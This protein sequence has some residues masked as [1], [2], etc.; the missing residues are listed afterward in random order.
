MVV[1]VKLVFANFVGEFGSNAIFGHLFTDT[2]VQLAHLRALAHFV[3][4]F[5][6]IACGLH[7][8]APRGCP[9]L[10]RPRFVACLALGSG[11]LFFSFPV[12]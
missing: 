7:G 11:F 8:A 6:E 3:A 12:S 4:F 2:R 9:D 5:I 10:Q 1:R